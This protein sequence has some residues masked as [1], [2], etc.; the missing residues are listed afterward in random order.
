M[1]GDLSDNI[2][3]VLMYLPSGA[4]SL[5]HLGCISQQLL[6]SF[7]CMLAFPLLNLLVSPPFLVSY[8][9]VMTDDI[10][11]M[12]VCIFLILALFLSLFSIFIYTSYCYNDFPSL[13][14]V[15]FVSPPNRGLANWHNTYRRQDRD[16]CVMM[17]K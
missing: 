1:Q 3:H 12:H 14:F 17:T 9:E 7:L 16:G 8:M 2:G 4:L 5:Y 11:S 10:L 15:I 13:I 6:S